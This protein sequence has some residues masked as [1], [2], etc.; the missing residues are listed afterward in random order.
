[1]RLIRQFLTEILLAL[2][3]W[4]IGV[5]PFLLYQHFLLRLF[6]RACR[7]STRSRCWGVLV[8]AV[9]VS[10]AAEPSSG[11]LPPGL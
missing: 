4:R 11:L 1:M 5:L 3:A 6:R 7:T 8:F 2:P 9:H 10:A